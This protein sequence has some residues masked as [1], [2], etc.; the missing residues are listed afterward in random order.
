MGFK[1]QNEANLKIKIASLLARWIRD[2]SILVRHTYH[3]AD[4]LLTDQ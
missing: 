2:L 3:C 1:M 4:V